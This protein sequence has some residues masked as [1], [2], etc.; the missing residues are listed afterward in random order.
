MYISES[1]SDALVPRQHIVVTMIA[2]ETSF[3]SPVEEVYI[4]QVG[5]G[6]IVLNFCYGLLAGSVRTRIWAIYKDIVDKNDEQSET[7]RESI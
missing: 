1:V 2:L 6:V 5:F 7:S 3:Q 4:D